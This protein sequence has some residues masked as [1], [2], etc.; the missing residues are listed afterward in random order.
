MLLDV[1]ENSVTYKGQNIKNQSFAIK[2]EKIFYEYNGDYTDQD[3]V[4]QF[5]REMQS[6]ME[7]EF[8]I[9]DYERGIPVISKI[10]L[11]TNS[12]NEI[13]SVL[14]REDITV[15]RNREIKMYTQYMGV[16][17]IMDALCK[18]QVERLNDYK[19]AKYTSD[20]AINI[21][22]LLKYVLGNNSDIMERELSVAVLGDTKLFE[23]SYKSRICSI[24]EEYGE[25]ELDLSVL[26]KKEKEKANLEEYQVFSNPSYIFFKGNVDIHYVDGNSISVTPDNPI[27]ILS[28][29]IAR[30]E[31]IKVNSN[32]IVTVENLTSY[33][34]I[35]DNK[36]TFIYL[37][38]Y[39]NTAKQRFLKK[40]AENN[41]GVSWF[42]FGD[43]DPDG[44]YILKNL[45]EK[46][47]I[48][49]VPLYMDVQQLINCKQY[50]KPLEKN[51]MVKANS[52][53]K[54]HFYDEVMEFMLANN[55]K[56]EQ[57]I[58]SWLYE[59]N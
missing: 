4:N 41:S 19:D 3:E 44:Y 9:L 45:V 29:A 2:P 28:E 5:N 54:F 58:I 42:H 27:A 47:G 51:D 57:E 15:K 18:S 12:I 14:K 55:C 23:K 24:I 46:T 49:F 16:H 38:G 50:C 40:I 31:M 11:N 30:I 39:H 1:Y 53:L 35:N 22:K 43:I 21:L 13:Y 8:V 25:L 6:L 10:K 20:I 17:D 56:L 52:L 37:S 32:R 48:A 7:F 59:R 33:N 34:R 36:S 26:D